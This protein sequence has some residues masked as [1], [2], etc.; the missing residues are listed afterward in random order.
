MGL[1]PIVL[2]NHEIPAYT[3]NGI[4]KGHHFVPIMLDNNRKQVCEVSIHY[5]Q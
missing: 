1:V 2:N 3:Q 5:L 4:K